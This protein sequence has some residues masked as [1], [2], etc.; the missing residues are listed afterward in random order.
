MAPT[1]VPW[2]PPSHPC[3]LEGGEY[4][5]AERGQGGQ[6]LDSGGFVR[7][8]RRKASEGGRAGPQG[9]KWSR[10]R[11]EG[12]SCGAL[13]PSYP[14]PRVPGRQRPGLDGRVAGLGRV[15]SLPLH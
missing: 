3:G 14:V 2:F 6:R 1:C 13:G 12:E 11:S 9:E 8:A 5:A 7:R 4:L 10:C 15:L